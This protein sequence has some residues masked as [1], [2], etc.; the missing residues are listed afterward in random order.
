M[1]KSLLQLGW[2][3]ENNNNNNKM[4]TALHFCSRNG[5]QNS[6]KWRD[7]RVRDFF[8]ILWCY[9]LLTRHIVSFPNH[10]DWV[11][12]NVFALHI[13]LFFRNS[14][15]LNFTSIPNI[16]FPQVSTRKISFGIRKCCKTKRSPTDHVIRACVL[17]QSAP[18]K[19]NQEK[20]PTY[21]CAPREF[22]NQIS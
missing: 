16:L 17:S 4:K 7:F 12:H 5:A 18:E 14:S 13:F 3:L 10:S 8:V 6:S 15:Q 1:L 20:K 22:L 9:L 11:T 21:L 19:H 2:K